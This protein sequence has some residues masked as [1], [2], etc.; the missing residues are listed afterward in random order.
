MDEPTKSVDVMTGQDLKNFIKNTLVDQDNKTIFLTTHRLE[1]AEA[2][3]DRLAIINKGKIQ[4]SGT[5]GEL[6]EKRYLQNKFTISVAGISRVNITKIC[7]H[8]SLDN[9]SIS[10]SDNADLH[11][12]VDFNV[13]N[14]QNPV[15]NIV[16][17][18]IARGGS[19]VSCNKVEPGLEELFTDLLR[20][21]SNVV[22]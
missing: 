18:I 20:E 4:F 22:S 11:H 5:I 10:S 3:C 21:G 8:R 14:G 2:L 16:E 7:D 15:S 13:V 9:L 12:K 1:E 19:L 6:R 17:K